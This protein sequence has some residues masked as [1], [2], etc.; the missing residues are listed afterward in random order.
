MY[1]LVVGEKMTMPVRVVAHGV[2]GHA[3]V[4][5]LGDNALV[6][7]APVLERLSAYAPARR[8]SPE[9]DTLLDVARAGR[10]SLDERIERGRA[11]HAELPPL[12]PAMA[13]LD[14]RADDGGRVAQAQRDSRP[15]VR[16]VR[17]SRAPRHRGRRA[18]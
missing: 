6:K 9:L 18:A 11:Q 16:R 5:L 14:D 10:G 8:T 12:L 3:S 1:T 17:L 2:A 4:P 13:G 7:L 15:R